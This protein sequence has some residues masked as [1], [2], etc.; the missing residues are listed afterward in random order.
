MVRA[1]LTPDEVAGPAGT[2]ATAAATAAGTAAATAANTAAAG[3]P[4]TDT[5]GDLEPERLEDAHRHD[6]RLRNE[7]GHDAGHRGP[8]AVE[9]VRQHVAGVGGPARAAGA[10]TTGPRPGAAPAARSLL[11]RPPVQMFLPGATR[12][13][14]GAELASTPVSTTA[15]ALFCPS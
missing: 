6:G 5:Q 1:L 2:A 4:A 14:N 8:V 9:R 13:R 12:P 15:T 3:R 7:L 11:P 10:A